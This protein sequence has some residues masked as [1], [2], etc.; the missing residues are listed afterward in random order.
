MKM[1]NEKSAAEKISA[2]I[3][4]ALKADEVSAL[5]ET[6]DSNGMFSVATRYHIVGDAIR[7][8]LSDSTM[9]DVSAQ[10]HQALL[11]E[12]FDAPDSVKST[13]KSSEGDRFGFFAWLESFARPL[14]GMA[15]AV[16]VAAMVVTVVQLESPENNSQQLASS[17]ENLQVPTLIVKKQSVDNLLNKQQRLTEFDDYLTEHAEFAAQDTLQGR[18]PYVRSVSYE[19]K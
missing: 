18:I 16:S 17:P 14:T 2:Y 10:V 6:N 9:V 13:I 15:V 19:V 4:D 8:E 3:D 1:N 5:L 12:S 11:Q 7:G